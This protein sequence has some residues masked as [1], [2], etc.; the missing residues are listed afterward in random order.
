[1]SLPEDRKN[2]GNGVTTKAFRIAW[3]KKADILSVELFSLYHL[4]KVSCSAWGET[5]G[6]GLVCYPAFDFD[7]LNGEDFRFERVVSV[8]E[9]RSVRERFEQVLGRPVNLVPGASVG[10]LVGEAH[11]K[12]SEDFIWGTICFP[13][14]AERFLPTVL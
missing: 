6:E 4:P 13:Q 3:P 10:P 14:S 7:F 8:D 12:P 11:F 5:W 9:F 2:G 1:M